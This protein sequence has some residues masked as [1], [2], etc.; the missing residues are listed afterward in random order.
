MSFDLNSL[1]RPHIKDLK[2]YT[3]ARDEYSGKEGIFLDANENPL[4]SVTQENF[5]RYPDP[6]QA[7]LKEELS[8]IKEVDPKQ[9]FLGNGSDEAIDLLFR[10][11]CNPGKDNVILLPPTYGMYEVSAN[12][13]D[14]EVRK[15]SLTADFQLQPLKILEAADQHSKILFICSP[16]NPSGN[17]V[18]R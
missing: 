10:A 17:K 5:N 11:F 3:S 8:I 9:I 14:V 15:V 16:N 2:P 4:G 12:I 7:S 1:L 13:N 18:K 6:Y